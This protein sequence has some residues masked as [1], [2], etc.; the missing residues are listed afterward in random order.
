[1]ATH[2]NRPLDEKREH[3]LAEEFREAAADL[4]FMADLV[5]VGRDLDAVDASLSAC[6]R[7]RKGAEQA[8]NALW[9]EEGEG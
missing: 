4:L 3:G 7:S 8:G 5:E 2:A 1:M 9:A 6:A